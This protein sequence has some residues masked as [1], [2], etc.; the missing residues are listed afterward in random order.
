MCETCTGLGIYAHTALPSH[1]NSTL[2][3]AGVKDIVTT[4]HT[5][6]CGAVHMRDICRLCQN[7]WVRLRVSECV[8]EYVSEWV[9]VW[10]CVWVSEGVWVTHTVWVYVST[11][12]PVVQWT[13]EWLWLLFTGLQLNLSLP[14]R[15][16]L[17]PCQTSSSRACSPPPLWTVNISPD[18]DLKFLEYCK[19]QPQ[20]ALYNCM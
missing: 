8:S 15:C 19:F 14:T 5:R 11:C 16:L 12:W 9:S 6:F 7:V 13:I 17:C 1:T 3:T 10:V 18:N 20:Y 4:A 2:S